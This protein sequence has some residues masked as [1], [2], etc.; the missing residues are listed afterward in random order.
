MGFPEP[1]NLRSKEKREVQKT[2]KCFAI[3][4]RQRQADLN[5]RSIVNDK[6]RESETEQLNVEQKNR[7][8]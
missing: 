5:F 4:L 1:G 7:I 6:F 8:L 3:I 2:L